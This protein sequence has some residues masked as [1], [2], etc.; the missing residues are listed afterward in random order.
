MKAVLVETGH[1]ALALA[2]ALS[3]VQAVMPAWAARAGEPAL[4]QVAVQAALGSFAC[5]LFA[6]AALT[7][8]NA[9]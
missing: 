5:V 2:L 9:T 7:Y 4:R 3:L 8:A 6:F 1:F